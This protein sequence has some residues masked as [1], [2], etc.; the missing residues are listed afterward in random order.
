MWIGQMVGRTESSNVTENNQSQ[1]SQICLEG[2]PWQAS[3]LWGVSL[4]YV[5]DLVSILVKY[6]LLIHISY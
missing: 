5:R 6:V 3:A 1:F 4:L 2:M